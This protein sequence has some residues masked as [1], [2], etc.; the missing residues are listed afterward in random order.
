MSAPVVSDR[1]QLPYPRRLQI[2]VPLLPSIVGDV[3]GGLAWHWREA[4]SSSS[5]CSHIPAVRAECTA[6]V[7]ADGC[8]VTFLRDAFALSSC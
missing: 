2:T 3:C 7:F 6:A 8:L 5:V 4:F 1:R